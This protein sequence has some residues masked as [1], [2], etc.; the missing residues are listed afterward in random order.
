MF[1]DIPHLGPY[2]NRCVSHVYKIPDHMTFI[3]ILITFIS[4]AELCRELTHPEFS[5][6]CEAYV[7]RVCIG[8]SFILCSCC[9]HNISASWW[10]NN[11]TILSIS[12]HC[13]AHLTSLIIEYAASCKSASHQDSGRNSRNLE[14]WNNMMSLAK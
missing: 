13:Q 6:H 9:C 1:S 5:Q 4:H 2:A 11:Q 12:V 3:Y 7:N 14:V 10:C 8:V